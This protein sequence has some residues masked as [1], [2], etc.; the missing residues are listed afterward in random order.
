MS[1]AALLAAPCGLPP[2][3]P[4]A[5][6]P[7]RRRR[8]P[9]T[10][11]PAAAAAA[12]Q[13]AIPTP[14]AALIDP[15]DLSARDLRGTVVVTGAGPAGL[16]AAA[17]LHQAGLAVLL[18]ERAPVLVA[19]CSALGLW[20]NAWRA[21]EALGAA[22]P[23]RVQH[24]ELQ[25]IE[26]VRHAGRRLRR[27][28]LAECD[29][30]PHEFRGVRRSNLQAALAARLPERSLALGA[31]VAAAQATASGAALRLESGQRLECLAVV[32]ADGARSAVA[33]AAGRAAPNYCGQS[34]IRGVA[35]FPQGIPAELQARC[36]RQ[37]WGPGARAGT[38]AISDTELYW[39]VCFF[40]PADLAAPPEPERWREEALSVV[41][42]WAWGLPEAV[43][44]T[45]AE[46]LSRS[47]LVDRWDLPPLS[48]AGGPSITLAGDALHPMTPNLG[49]GGCT[50]LEDALVLARSL[51]EQRVPTL[52]A[53]LGD[54]SSSGGDG[55]QRR[56]RAAE[57][58]QAALRRYEQQRAKRCLPLTV[59]SNLMGAALQ[60]PLP[61]VSF[62]RDLFV[63]NA[64]NPA[65]FL[66]HAAFDC[67]RLLPAQ[68]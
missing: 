57:A 51:Q 64:F 47:R 41:C 14:P 28:S 55:E 13:A 5:A 18:L 50:A 65:H 52:A 62:A 44:A 3:R 9:P 60:A 45:P 4:F 11:A 23:L 34:A 27:F 2:A 61:P 58:V 32:G 67:G 46:D 31:P 20:T 40:A 48:S 25:D 30:G 7:G 37:V 17:A 21:L 10:V 22:D 66:D 49:Q 53:Q 1:V 19:G 68:P 39:F 15:S 42:G 36:I 24:P 56:Q 54:G 6:P 59:R 12:Q 33:A 35:R 63:Q 26:L 16:A 43:A 8:S 29:G 38:Y